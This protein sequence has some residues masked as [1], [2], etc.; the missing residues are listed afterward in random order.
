MGF[1]LEVVGV[2]KKNIT[3]R[4]HI[5]YAENMYLKYKTDGLDGN[6]SKN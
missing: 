3:R 6:I 4:R 2:G 5:K 1:Q